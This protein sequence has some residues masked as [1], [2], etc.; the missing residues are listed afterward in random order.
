MF[1]EE[2]L[3]FAKYSKKDHNHFL[4]RDLFIIC[5][6]NFYFFLQNTNQNDIV[7][8]EIFVLSDVSDRHDNVFVKKVEEIIDT[9]L[10]EKGCSPDVKHQGTDGCSC[11]YKSRYT[12]Y[13]ISSSETPLRRCYYTTSHAKGPQDAAGGLVKRMADM[14]VIRRQAVIQSAL[15][16]QQFCI[17]TLSQP[18][19][20]KGNKVYRRYFHLV[21][22][23]EI[24]A[25]GC[26]VPVGP[27]EGIRSLHQ[28]CSMGQTGTVDTRKLSC[29]TCDECVE[30]NYDKC[31]NGEICG[32]VKRVTLVQ[33]DD[34]TQDV[35]DEQFS[36]ADSLREKDIVQIM[37]HTDNETN[38]ELIKVTKPLYKLTREC[39]DDRGDGYPRGSMILRG[40]VLKENGISG[41][42]H[43]FQTTPVKIMFLG[44]S[45][46]SLVD[47]TAERRKILVHNDEYIR[48]S[49]Q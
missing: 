25:K 6:M 48:L 42:N 24:P 34:N 35:D 16:L 23:D 43:V 47:T 13:D 49:I 40:Q 17:K 36:L 37:H 1:S 46:I 11:Q 8:E 28:I 41:A 20:R 38:T 32:P 18:K 7:C 19:E 33:G 4:N 26:E 27:L 15:D 3:G 2:E 12:S 29:Y 31:T 22:A 5:F 10:S 45:V 30:G 44:S 39:F 9:H 21:T 14:A